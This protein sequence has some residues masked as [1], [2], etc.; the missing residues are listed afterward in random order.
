VPRRPGSRV[1]V[2]NRRQCPE[3]ERSH[4]ERIREKIAAKRRR[5]KWAGGRPI[6]GY[7]VDRTGPSPKLVVILNVLH[8][9]PPE[10]R[11][12]SHKSPAHHELRS[13]F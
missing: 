5:G 1:P 12:V 6:L 7:D 9:S 3:I 10:S 4:R 2:L 13:S 11:S 8:Q